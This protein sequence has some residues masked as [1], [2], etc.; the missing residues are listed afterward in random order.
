MTGTL[1]FFSLFWGFG[2]GR[3][4]CGGYWLCLVYRRDPRGDNRI[5]IFP[6][7]AQLQAFF[8]DLKLSEISAFHHINNL[9]DC[10]KVQEASSNLG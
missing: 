6:A 2:C 7:N 5:A 10:F 8:L 9:L 1:W 4:G 3:R